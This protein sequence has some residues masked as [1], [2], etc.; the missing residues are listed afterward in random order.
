[1]EKLDYG[2]IGNGRT[3]ALVSLEGSIDWFCLPDFDSPSV[4]GKILDQN[5]GGTLG[6]LNYKD[7]HI[8]Q[9]YIDHTN[10]LITTF[11]S[12]SGCFEVIDFMPRYKINDNT[13]YFIPSE[14]YRYIRLK[15]GH[16]KIKIN[17]DPRLNYAN[18]EVKHKTGPEYIK[19]GI[20][21]NIHDAIY[22][23]SSIDFNYIL[24]QKEFELSQDEFILISYNQKVIKVDIERVCLE[25]ERTKLYWM[26][27]SN[28]S[29]QYTRF[30]N[31]I[32]RSMLVLK[33]M[34]YQRTGA[35]LAALTT[36]I[37]ESIG[38]VRNWD[39]RYCWLRDASMSIET[40]IKTGHS[41]AARSFMGFIQNILR[42][43]YDSLQ[44]MY[45]IR[46][47]RDIV[48]KELPYLSGYKNSRPVRIGNA[49]YS[50]RQNDSF[51]YLMNVIY[52][53]YLYFRGTL[54]EVEEMFEVVKHICR[55]VLNDWHSH[56]SG[57]WEMRNKKEHFVSSK[58]MCW[59]TLDRAAKI[60]GMLYKKGYSERY[61]IEA[62][63]IK[64]DVLLH[65]WKEEIQSFSQTYSNIELDS[66]LLLMEKYGFI[67]AEDERY[68]KTVNAVYDKLYY[69]GL[70]FR[71]NNHD[72]FGIPNS[73]FTV[74]T[75]WMV[76]GLY[77]TGRKS[78]AQRLFENLLTYSNHL[79][80]FSEDLDFT[81]KEQL[82]N[83]P[84]AYSHLALIDTALLFSKEIGLSKFIRP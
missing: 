28:R 19:S 78:E 73:A 29:K 9:K 10:V 8:K 76:R 81:T 64:E 14:L 47:E 82:G 11:D 18:G 1:M 80:L 54:D 45:G 61:R 75:F 21:G 62:Q 55:I 24:N 68:I 39:Y 77:V 32:E 84:Q 67:A 43:K 49:A 30:N 72:D 33:L 38:S 26:N 51:G 56:D 13:N 50:Q 15:R 36:S 70:M 46:Y 5:I 79:G 83:F 34:S 23:Y 3:A 69:K 12:E 71:Y 53:Y 40:L 52:Q 63:K 37:P 7:Y 57:I 66:S 42:S 74:C 4:F 48:E 22:L 6:F 65:G 2:V 60:A 16:P 27:W 17:Y 58:I 20:D 35:V 31:F 25:Y 44:I 59:V 41:G